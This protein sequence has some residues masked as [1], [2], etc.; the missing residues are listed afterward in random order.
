MVWDLTGGSD[1]DGT[2]VGYSF[3]TNIRKIQLNRVAFQVIICRDDESLRITWRIWKLIPVKVKGVFA[4]A[5]L[6]SERL[7][8][9]PLPSYGGDTNGQPSTRAEHVESEY[10]E[11]GTIVNEVTV[12]TTT[13]TT[14]KRYRVEDA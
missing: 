11:F 14:R 8:S 13:V 3:F 1:K 2:E 7:G 12:T 4:P 6:L 5:E 9:D 10:D